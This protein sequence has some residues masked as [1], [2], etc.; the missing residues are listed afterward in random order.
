MSLGIQEVCFPHIL[1]CIE[2]GG[3]FGSFVAFHFFPPH[4]FSCCWESFL[5]NKNLLA[6]SSEPLLREGE[7]SHNGYLMT[8]PFCRQIS[9]WERSHYCS[10]AINLNAVAQGPSLSPCDGGGGGNGRGGGG[11][12]GRDF[13]KNSCFLP[14]TFLK[15]ACENLFPTNRIWRRHNSCTWYPN[16]FLKSPLQTQRLTVL[17]WGSSSLTNSGCFI[18]SEIKMHWSLPHKH[19]TGS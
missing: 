4:P 15:C 17:S 13:F 2:P 7:S 12:E 16:L 11:E 8:S 1:P 3:W 14:F 10:C 6:A 5:P 9:P 19:F 18:S